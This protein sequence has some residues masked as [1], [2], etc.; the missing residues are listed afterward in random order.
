MT[1]GYFAVG[2]AQPK[3][4][5]NVGSAL[6]ACGCFGARTFEHSVIV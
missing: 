5:A 4:P 3:T 2:L 6:R 1:R